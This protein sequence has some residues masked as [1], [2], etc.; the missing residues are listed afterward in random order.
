MARERQ[1]TPIAT[2]RLNSADA[3][4]ERP[5]QSLV[6]AVDALV[7][8]TEDHFLTSLTEDDHQR[9][10]ASLDKLL[11]IVGENENHFLVPLMDFIDNLIEKHEEKPNK[12]GLRLPG[13]GFRTTSNT[14]EPEYTPAQLDL[15]NSQYQDPAQD[16][17]SLQMAGASPPGRGLRTASNADELEYTPAQLDLINSQ[18]QDPAEK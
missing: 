9:L 4:A 1:T 6:A 12:T 13:R 7:G 14:D 2:A 10:V 11:D 18:Y 16:A 8:V 15:I 5:S 3:T 17:V